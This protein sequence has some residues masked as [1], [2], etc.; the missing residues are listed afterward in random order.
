MLLSHLIRALRW[1]Q[2]ISSI[3]YDVRISKTFWA[4]LLGYLGNVI[5]PR[6]GEIARCGALSKSEHVPIEKL[7]GTV[8]AERFV[9]LLFM[10]V[11]ISIAA[12]VEWQRIAD[13]WQAR[14]A[15]N[16]NR[17]KDGLLT[18]NNLLILLAGVAVL[19]GLFYLIHRY[20]KGRIIEKM[21]SFKDGLVEG[22]KSLFRLKNP[23][24]FLSY[25]ILLWVV[26]YFSSYVV[27]DALTETSHL[28]F[29]AGLSVLSMG[30]IGLVIPTPGGL[31]SFHKIVTETLQVYGIGLTAATAYP[32]IV[33]T[34]QFVV[35]LFGGL[36]ALYQLWPSNNKTN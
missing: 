5:I 6:S 36:V 2:I 9:D 33:W 15:P 13:L 31:G 27:F 3:N 22:M 16:L 21:A 32:W 26:Y 8:I 11:A 35:I 1:K 29:G 14:V 19:A 24:L 20:F 17:L 30:S 12:Y 18:T 7:I 23:A 34:S 25:S 10:V 4:I 28:G